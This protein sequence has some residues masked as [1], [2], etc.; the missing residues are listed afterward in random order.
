MLHRFFAICCMAF[1][2]CL[3]GQ[4]LAT[5]S[6]SAQDVWV[7]TAD[8]NQIFVE[9]DT[10]SG[11]SQHAT[12]RTKEVYNGQLVRRVIWYFNKMGSWRYHTSTM[13]GSND[14]AVI[15]NGEAHAILRACGNVLGFST[16][17]QESW[18]D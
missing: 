14:S 13:R 18:V 16:Y 2:L 5:P 12:A 11:N 15:A 6:A 1:T 7:C 17:V 8:G 10:I 4:F 3:G 9:T